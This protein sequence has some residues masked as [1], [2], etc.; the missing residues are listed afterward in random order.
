MPP[1]WR[2]MLTGDPGHG[3]WLPLGRGALESESAASGAGAGPPGPAG[4]GRRV[5]AVPSGAEERGGALCLASRIVPLE[6]PCAL[7]AVGPGLM[8]QDPPC[9]KNVD[10]SASTR[11]REGSNRKHLRMPIKDGR[12]RP[13][14]SAEWGD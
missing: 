13:S 1:E 12:Q 8:R 10:D 9:Q 5:L 14:K 11:R 6:A 7:R 3:S 2:E 4:P